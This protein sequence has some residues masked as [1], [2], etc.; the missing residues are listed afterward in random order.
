MIKEPLIIGKSRAIKE[1]FAFARKAAKSDSNVVILGETGVGKELAA[2]MIHCLSHRK[3]KPFLKINCANLNDNLLESE[4]F[5]HKKGAY[6]GAFFDKFGLIEEA[7]QGTFF[8]DEI[9]DISFNIQAKLLGVIEDKEIRRIGENKGRKIDVRF[10][11][12]TNKNI[13][14]LV[15]RNRFRQDLFY[16]IS[17]LTFYIPP[18]RERSEDINLLIDKI[19]DEKKTKMSFDFHI[20]NEA[21][22]KLFKYSFPGNVRELENIIKRACEL[23]EHG[24]I[25]E[26]DIY[27]QEIQNKNV[28]IKRTRFKMSK[29]IDALIKYQGN[30]TKVAKELGMSRTQ[31][32]R[33]LNFEDE[34]N[35][36]TKEAS[37]LT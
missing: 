28:R 31:L 3:E 25:R 19:L 10:I 1:F 37:S 22:N 12:A 32:Y 36:K 24:V 30:K 16:R 2:K 9:A 7:N 5:G 34:K 23:S 17:I 29:I 20:T 8:F 11:F 6:T 13:N 35:N 18:L 4:L 33:I 27:F 15:A 14:D 26:E 21:I